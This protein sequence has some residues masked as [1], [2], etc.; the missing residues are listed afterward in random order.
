M[1]RILAV[2]AF[3]PA[4]GAGIGSALFTKQ[5]IADAAWDT[6]TENARAIVEIAR[7]TRP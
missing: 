7:A 1:I 4:A 3:S 5:L 2:A 6:I